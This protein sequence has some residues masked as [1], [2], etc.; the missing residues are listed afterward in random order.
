M[1]AALGAE[2]VLVDQAPGSPPG[3]VSGDDLALVEER[4]RVIVAEREGFR[5]DQFRLQA[6]P[7]AHERTTG[8]ELWDQSGGR[9]DVF[10]D[11]VGSGG[12]FVGVSRYLRRVNPDVRTYV[13]EPASAPVLAGDPVTDPNHRIQGGGYSMDDLPLFDRSLVTGYLRV[14]DDEAVRTAR[15]VARIEGAFGG[16]S[17]GANLAAAVTLL[18]GAEAGAT[19]AVLACDSGLKYLSTDLYA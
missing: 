11:F 3:Q 4:T 7:R 19:V 2:V 10:A 12:S 9:I 18:R 17:T 13:V 14:T 15:E 8:P 5:A 16:F 6:N 1:M